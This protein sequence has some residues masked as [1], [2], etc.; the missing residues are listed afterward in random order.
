MDKIAAAYQE[1]FKDNLSGLLGNVQKVVQYEPYNVLLTDLP[2]IYIDLLQSE[3][4][5]YSW[6]DSID[7]LVKI[8]YIDQINNHIGWNNDDIFELK[9][10]VVSVME[11]TDNSWSLRSDTIMWVIRD[12]TRLAYNPWPGVINLSVDIVRYVTTYAEVPDNEGAIAMIEWIANIQLRILRS[13]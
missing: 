6:F 8:G 3:Y 5:V 13:T 4:N 11:W 2:L 10:S 1:I 7:A 9:K 12:N